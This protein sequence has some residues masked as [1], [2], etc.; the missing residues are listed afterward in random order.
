MY[1]II[2]KKLGRPT[3]RVWGKVVW[4]KELKRDFKRFYKSK[5]TTSKLKMSVGH[6]FMYII[7][8]KKLGR[9]TLRVWGKKLKKRFKKFY[10]RKKSLQS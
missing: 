8:I 5:E 6:F 4:S 7:I 2:I 1:I 10:R 9:L 3:L